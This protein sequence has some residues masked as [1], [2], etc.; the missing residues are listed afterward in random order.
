[1][2][3]AGEV[4]ASSGYDVQ[5]EVHGGDARQ[6]AGV[7]RKLVEL[8]RIRFDPE[9]VE[10]RTADAESLARLIEQ[11]IDAVPSLD[12]DRILR[13]FLRVI[14][15]TLRTNYF[16]LDADGRPKPYLSFKLDPALVP[17]LPAAEA[18]VRDLGLLAASRGRA[19][20][21]GKVARGAFAGRTAARTSATRYSG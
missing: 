9:R 18:R 5:P 3:R 11:E 12:E 19:S 15:A 8:F 16:Q 2:L 6:C 20:P 14:Q 1:M 21:R 7:A 10:E 17:D 4:H 13:G